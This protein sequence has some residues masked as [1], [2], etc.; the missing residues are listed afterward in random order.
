MDWTM[1]VI[2]ERTGGIAGQHTRLEIPDGRTLNLKDRRAGERSR[3]L[4]SDE[5]NTLASHLEQVKK[6]S[7]PTTRPPRASDTFHHRLTINGEPRVDLATTGAAP[8]N[9][10][11][12]DAAL[13]AFLDGLATQELKK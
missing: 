9:D 3:A 12:A 4:T 5:Q 6:S 11:S 7:A 2:Y 8:P 1:S 13:I 10:G